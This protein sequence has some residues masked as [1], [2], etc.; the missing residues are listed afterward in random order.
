MSTQV[1]NKIPKFNGYNVYKGDAHVQ[2]FSSFMD[3]H[4]FG[5]QDMWMRFFVRPL[6]ARAR[7]WYLSFPKKSFPC[8]DKLMDAYRK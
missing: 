1:Y 5:Y 2:K 8:W 3:K 7:D 6:E 4:S